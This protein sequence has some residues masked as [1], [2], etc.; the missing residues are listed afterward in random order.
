MLRIYWYDGASV[1]GP[2]AQ[3]STWPSMKNIKLRLGF[4]NSHGEQKGVDSLIVTDLIELARNRALSDALLVSGD[5]DVRV[6][7]TIAQSCG[8]R[9]HLVGIVPSRGSQSQLLLQEAD[10]TTEWALDEISKF[11]SVTSSPTSV[12]E[13]SASAPEKLAEGASVDLERA[14]GETV[15]LISRNLSEGE[16][17]TILAQIAIPPDIDGKL[18]GTARDK[19]SRQLSPI[20]KRRLRDVFRQS[21]KSSGSSS[22]GSH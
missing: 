9:V 12:K 8:V 3:Q 18:L 21:L 14:F 16:I 15:A 11:L 4:I 5:E 10:T 2:T 19:L 7:V 1:A 22:K 13:S 6:G 17:A 20:E